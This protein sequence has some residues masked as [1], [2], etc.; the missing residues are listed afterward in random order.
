M[1]GPNLPPPNNTYEYEDWYGNLRQKEG[2]TF[3]YSPTKP[4]TLA[5]VNG[6]AVAKGRSLFKDRLGDEVASP[7]ITG[8]CTSSNTTSG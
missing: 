7:L 5:T 6:E 3:T 2:T 4:H 8:I 1:N